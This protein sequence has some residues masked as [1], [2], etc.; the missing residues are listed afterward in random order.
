M[1]LDLN[2]SKK[3]HSVKSRGITSILTLG[4]SS[5]Y[6]QLLRPVSLVN[7]LGPSGVIELMEAGVCC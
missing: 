3:F 4:T 6:A 7:L 1:S 2:P 5:R